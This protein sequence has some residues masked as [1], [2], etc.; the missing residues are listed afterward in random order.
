MVDSAIN[1]RGQSDDVI[2][3]TDILLVF[4]LKSFYDH[5]H[6]PL[7]RTQS[8]EPPRSPFEMVKSPYHTNF[9]MR[10]GTPSA[11]SQLDASHGDFLPQE[12]NTTNSAVKLS[13]SE[14]SVSM[15]F[16]FPHMFS[17][18][19]SR[20]TNAGYIDNV[21]S[22]GSTEFNSLP[23]RKC[24]FHGGEYKTNSLP[25][26]DKL[27][28]YRNQY[29]FQDDNDNDDND[30]DDS[31]LNQQCA[32]PYL[33]AQNY[34]KRRYSCGMQEAQRAKN[35][36]RA[37]STV[38]GNSYLLR[39]NSENNFYLSHLQQYHLQSNETGEG[40][41]DDEKSDS[42]E[43]CSTCASDNE[44][45]Q[46]VEQAEKEIFIDFK[47]HVSPTPSLRNSKK[48]LQKAVSDG[49]AVMNK[50][51]DVG[52]G[53]S[54]DE[55]NDTVKISDDDMDGDT[56]ESTHQTRDKQK[57][58][59]LLCEHEHINV[60]NRREAFRK[61]SDSMEKSAGDEEADRYSDN[62]LDNKTKNEYPSTDSLG[63][64]LAR[65]YS[66]GGIWN[67]SQVTVLQMDST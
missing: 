37:H 39:R 16:G 58:P 28:H 56:K 25:R 15:M 48:R 35:Q 59:H 26:N 44:S 7:H 64:E 41:D 29:E 52:D 12:S 1:S 8:E 2:L 36:P 45:V 23:R 32:E 51:R 27:Q 60:H 38:N 21:S 49:D 33:H 55:A 66:D 61:R 20:G 47:P 46:E 62:R 31:M 9:V 17:S 34:L 54:A 43:Y 42:E 11:H 50:H 10:S 13:T 24:A 22:Q 63:N 4:A 53:D 19:I 65:D 67:E 5:Q 14:D 18:R 30:N 6:E 3:S 57:I 40:D